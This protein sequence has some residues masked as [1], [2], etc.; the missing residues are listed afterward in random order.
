[1][2]FPPS[3]K[4]GQAQNVVGDDHLLMLLISAAEEDRQLGAQQLASRLC[5]A[6][7]PEANHHDF[8]D[9]VPMRGA[10][11][12]HWNDL[13]GEFSVP[14][15][16]L[17]GF[18]LFGVSGGPL[19]LANVAATRYHLCFGCVGIFPDT[20]P[21]SCGAFSVGEGKKGGHAV[22]VQKRARAEYYKTPRRSFW[23]RVK[24]FLRC[25]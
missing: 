1:M 10:K 20:Q 9:G 13:S 14:Q 6:S 7:A 12:V 4:P 21:A 24:C 23:L 19:S 11:L 18:F 16:G 25:R 17:L 2:S 22:G 8:L 5:A 15:R 3:D